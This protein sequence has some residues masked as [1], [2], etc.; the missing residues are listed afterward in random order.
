[1]ERDGAKEAILKKV[2]QLK[3]VFYA[4]GIEDP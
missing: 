2:L 4:L 3:T 1:M